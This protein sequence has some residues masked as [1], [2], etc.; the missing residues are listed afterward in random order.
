MIVAVVLGLTVGAMLGFFFDVAFPPEYSFYITMAL[1]AALDSLF[2]A[3]R[4]HMQG[5]YSTM[6]FPSYSPK[7]SFAYCVAWAV[8]FCSA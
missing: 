3:A 6:I 8:P 5:Q 4:T 2:G 7:T 1:L